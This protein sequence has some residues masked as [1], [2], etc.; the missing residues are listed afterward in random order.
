MLTA[1]H[2]GLCTLAEI[3][4]WMCYGPA[5]AYRIPNKGK[6]LVGWDADLTLVDIG[7]IRPVRDEE[8]FTKV[9]WS[10][11]SGRELR[12]WPQYTIVNGEIAFDNGRIREH[13]RGR[14]LSYLH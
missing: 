8:T 5:E 10:P 6:I 14:P 12:G 13:V 3:Q 7:H 4:K 9:R 1:M 2:N 11:W